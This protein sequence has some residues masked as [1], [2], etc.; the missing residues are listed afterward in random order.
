M[1]PLLIVGA[2]G[3]GRETLAAAR[4]TNEVTPTWEVVGFLDDDPTVQ[5]TLIDGARVVGPTN[6]VA[7][8]PDTAAVVTIGNPG[9]FTSRRRI[10]S[11]LDL[12]PDRWATVVHPAAVVARGPGSA[13]ARSS[14]PVPSRPARSTSAPMWW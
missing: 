9:D 12:R 2:G 14:W 10:V 5:G 1:R 7:H 13:T 8:H 3:L 4:A 11:E 6:H